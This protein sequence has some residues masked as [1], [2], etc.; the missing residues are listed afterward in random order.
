MMSLLW[1]G[2]RGPTQSKQ[3]AHLVA[4]GFHQ[5]RGRVMLRTLKTKE[6]Q[7]MA[8]GLKQADAMP[9]RF[10]LIAAIFLGVIAVSQAARIYFGYDVLVGS[11]HVPMAISWGMAILC[12]GVAVLAFREGDA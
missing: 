11:Y 12:G 1:S 3:S 7:K 8:D 6:E 2:A 5:P 9:K 10:T 4:C